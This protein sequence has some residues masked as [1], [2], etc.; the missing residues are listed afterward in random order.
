MPYFK[1]FFGIAFV[2]Y[3]PGFASAIEIVEDGLSISLDPAAAELSARIPESPLLSVTVERPPSVSARARTEDSITA[4]IEKAEPVAPK[5]SPPKPPKREKRVSMAPAPP[6]LTDRFKEALQ[7]G[8]T[9]RFP[10][11]T[12]EYDKAALKSEAYDYVRIV[13]DVLDADLSLSIIIE[14]HTD[15]NGTDEYNLDLS[16]RRALAVKTALARLGISPDRL[17]AIGY[18]ERRPA[19]TNETPIGQANNRRVEFKKR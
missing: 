7:A 8:K 16:Q 11:I 6:S 18:G 4:A 13:K 9:L 19:D 10:E 2:L 15:S 1:F 17:H 14:G 3:L 5:L 12:F